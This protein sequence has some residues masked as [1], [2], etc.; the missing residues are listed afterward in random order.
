[1]AHFIWTGKVRTSCQ[2]RT[3]W[4]QIRCCRK[5]WKK[6]FV[7]IV[8][9]GSTQNLPSLKSRGGLTVCTQQDSILEMDQQTLGLLSV[10]FLRGICLSVILCLIWYC[11]SAGGG[12]GCDFVCVC[13][14]SSCC[15]LVRG[16]WNPCHPICTWWRKLLI[17][18]KL[19][20]STWRQ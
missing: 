5:Q 10:C 12:K 15:F 2:K 17:T 20:T 7:L 18:Q 14:C 1:M 4:G 6:E 9:P 13:V 3:L 11:I 8:N 16:S 19:H